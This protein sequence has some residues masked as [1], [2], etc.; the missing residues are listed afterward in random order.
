MRV[1]G[2]L[3]VVGGWKGCLGALVW[4]LEVGLEGA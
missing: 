4:A 3:S 1:C 2:E